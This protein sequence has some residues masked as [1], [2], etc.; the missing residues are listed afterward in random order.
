MSKKRKDASDAI[1]RV[2]LDRMPWRPLLSDPGARWSYLPAI[3]R[4]I[5]DELMRRLDAR[6]NLELG[7]QPR[8]V[9]VARAI[10]AGPRERKRIAEA[11]EELIESGWMVERDGRLE[12]SFPGIQRD[13]NELEREPNGS[14]TG[15]SGTRPS[16]DRASTE[17]RPV[18]DGAGSDTQ[19]STKVSESK[20]SRQEKREEEI[21]GD[22]KRGEDA[23]A[24]DPDE[25]PD[26]MVVNATVV[27]L[28]AA[29]K[30][31]GLT[32]TTGDMSSRWQ[33]LAT[34]VLEHAAAQTPPMPSSQVIDRLV[35]GFAANERAR[36]EGYPLAYLAKNPNEYLATPARRGPVTKTELD[37]EGGTRRV[38]DEEVWGGRR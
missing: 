9:A 36:A 26:P 2:S 35:A 32:M 17:H 27:A 6:H 21:R 38:S 8:A 30:K 15:A 13:S 28:R 25:A 37:M 16:I 29:L 22:E 3:T 34:W 18:P 7:G 24:P 33:V 11:V 4:G 5:A 1:P 14:R 20:E 31:V 12:A 23:R 19:P 10:G